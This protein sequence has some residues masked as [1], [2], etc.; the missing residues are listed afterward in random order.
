M[1]PLP[2]P[3]LCRLPTARSTQETTRV[4]LAAELSA[5]L[6]FAQFF[7]STQTNTHTVPRSLTTPET[8]HIARPLLHGRLPFSIQRPCIEEKR[9]K[10]RR[11][12]GE[13]N[14]GFRI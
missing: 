7:Q 11:L 3:P 10:G 6:R 14:L 12:S 1:L 5:L 13:G 9:L 2:S 8:T 4:E